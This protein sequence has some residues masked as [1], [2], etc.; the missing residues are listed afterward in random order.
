MSCGTQVFVDF[1]KLILDDVPPRKHANTILN[2][3]KQTMAMNDYSKEKNF[4]E[5]ELKLFRTSDIR[6]EK[7]NELGSQL[8][9]TMIQVNLNH[10]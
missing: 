9:V 3:G 5:L 10:L 2:K 4:L 8:I 6:A 1:K 7:E